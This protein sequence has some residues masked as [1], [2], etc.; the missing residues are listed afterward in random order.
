MNL[1]KNNLKDV[2]KE[3]NIKS[4]TNVD[5]SHKQIA[6]LNDKVFE[7]LEN[8]EQLKFSLYINKMCFWNRFV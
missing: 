2:L 5:L 8:I 3:D 4:L 7:E 1:T 6:N